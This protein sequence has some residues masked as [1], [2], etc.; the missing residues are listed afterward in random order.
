MFFKK[1]SPVE[2]L[3]EELK[4]DVYSLEWDKLADE[5]TVFINLQ[6]F[7]DTS[8]RIH[9]IERHGKGKDDERTVVFTIDTEQN[10][11]L[12]EQVYY[13]SRAQHKQLIQDWQKIVDNKEPP[14]DN[15]S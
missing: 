9:S 10:R 7:E 2:I 11:R 12:D 6:S 15:N 13:I 1:K 5:L 14:A 8:R 4:P 3:A